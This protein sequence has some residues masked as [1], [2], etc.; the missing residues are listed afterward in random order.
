MSANN[1]YTVT[2]A[3]ATEKSESLKQDKH[4]SNPV[5]NYGCYMFWTA[6]GAMSAQ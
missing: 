4:D 6:L 5:I 2:M 3:L 1:N